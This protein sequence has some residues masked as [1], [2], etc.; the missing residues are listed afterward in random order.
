ML[1]ANARGESLPNYEH[2]K[3]IEAIV[4]LDEVPEDSPAFSEWIKAEAHLSFLRQNAQA[5]E[6]VI[7]ASG[8]YT[9]IN[10]VIVPTDRLTPINREDLMRWSLTSYGSIAGYTWGGGRDDLWIERGLSGTGTTTLEGAL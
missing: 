3:L 7:Y 1:D 9:F 4:R 10:A 5:D 2:K 8:E 6:L